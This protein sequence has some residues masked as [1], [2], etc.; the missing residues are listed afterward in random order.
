MTTIVKDCSNYPPAPAASE[1]LSRTRHTLQASPTA[2]RVITITHQSDRNPKNR[3]YE[4]KIKQ[5]K[6]YSAFTSDTVVVVLN[7]IGAVV[8]TPVTLWKFFILGT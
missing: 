6:H 7:T 2:P 8:F 4:Q 5:L 1:I 3:L